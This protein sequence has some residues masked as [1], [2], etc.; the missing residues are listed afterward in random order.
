[1]ET[2]S[3]LFVC[4]GNICRSPL[5][6]GIFSDLVS[7]HG[8]DK[9]FRIDSCGTGSWHIGKPPH[10]DTIEVAE[11]HGVEVSHLRARQFTAKDFDRFDLIVAMDEEN[12]Q[13]IERLRNK[14]STRVCLLREYDGEEDELSV[15]DP[16][17]EG[18]FEG[19]YEIIRRSCCN[20]FD[21]LQNS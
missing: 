5:A 17:Y 21:E 8:L 14:S 3:V 2:R 15:P 10:E 18:D 11:A 12:L 9:Q 1:M 20:L 16:Y 19:V 4:L 6:E 7:S 13:D